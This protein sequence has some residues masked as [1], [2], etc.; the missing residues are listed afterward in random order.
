MKLPWWIVIASGPSLT[1]VDCDLLR[2]VGKTIAVNNAVFYAP[3]ADILYAGDAAWWKVYGPDV[4]WFKGER[5]THQEYKN[6]RVF[7][8]SNRF[9]RFGGNSG[10]QALQ[11]A[12]HIGARRVAIIGFDHQHTGGRA[13]FHKDH[14][15]QTEIGG[16][17][18]LLGNAACSDHWIKIMNGTASDAKAMGIE[19]VNLS[20]Q[21]ALDCFPQMSVEEF[22]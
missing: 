19:I 9:K 1:R 17:L 3:W 12:I 16:E 18:V 20:R 8:G 11:Y 14:V 21:T 5:V 6:T 2:G 13:H 7:K 4:S 10:H 22:V 15:R